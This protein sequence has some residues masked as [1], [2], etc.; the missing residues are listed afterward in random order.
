M[1]S[2]N[3]PIP[4]E[5]FKA[6]M[7]TLCDIIYEMFE[8]GNDNNIIDAKLTIFKLLRVFIK[9]S[10]GK[11]LIKKFITKTHPFWNRIKDRDIEYFTEVGLSIFKIVD[12]K[13]LDEIADKEDKGSEIL[14]AISGSNLRDFKT[15]IES[16]YVVDGEK[17]EVFDQERKDD[18]WSIMDSFVKISICYIHDC[19]KKN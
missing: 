2:S 6:N 11:K 17:M 16:N 4:S 19:R 15:L 18:V 10:S 14:K 1:A 13:G 3:T 5:R 8:E 7:I 12:E 9:N